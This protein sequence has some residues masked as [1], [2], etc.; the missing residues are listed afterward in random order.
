M[1]RKLILIML[2][3]AGILYSVLQLIVP[4]ERVSAAKCCTVPLDCG[5]KGKCESKLNDCSTNSNKGFCNY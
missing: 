1:R 2:S 4:E 3:T 5:L